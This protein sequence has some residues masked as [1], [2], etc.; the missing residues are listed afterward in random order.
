VSYDMEFVLV[1]LILV[2]C[3]ELIFIVLVLTVKLKGGGDEVITLQAGKEKTSG[4]VSFEGKCLRSDIQILVL[5]LV[6]VIILV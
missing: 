6:M 3:L 4:K 2:L 5:L 1:S